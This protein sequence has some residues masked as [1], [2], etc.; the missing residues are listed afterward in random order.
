MILIYLLGC[1]NS[2]PKSEAPAKNDHPQSV[3]NGQTAGEQSSR[4][5]ASTP[6]SVE[7][8]AK[9]RALV[10][11][12][13]VLAQ[14]ADARSRSCIRPVLRGEPVPGSGSEMLFEAFFPPKDGP[15][16]SQIYEAN[17]KMLRSKSKKRRRKGE[18]KSAKQANRKGKGEANKTPKEIFI[19]DWSSFVSVCQAGIDTMRTAIQYEDNCSPLRAG[20]RSLQSLRHIT[21]LSNVIGAKIEQ[22]INVGEYRQG[23]NLMTDTL[24]A[25]QDIERGGTPFG[26]A[27]AG[28]GATIELTAP[29]KKLISVYPNTDFL[30][31]LVALQKTEISLKSFFEAE[32]LDADLTMSLPALH[33]PNWAPPG[34]WDKIDP[35]YTDEVDGIKTISMGKYTDAYTV[36]EST[37]RSYARVFEQC[38]DDNKVDD[39]YR[40]LQVLR[41]TRTPL[42]APENPAEAKLE[43]MIHVLNGIA[44]PDN[45]VYVLYASYRS[46]VLHAAQISIRW[47]LDGCPDINTFQAQN[48]SLLVDSR[49]GKNFP[50]SVDGSTLQLEPVLPL[51][52]KNREPLKWAIECNTL[53]K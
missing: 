4:E 3:N 40:G 25:L 30:A 48:L 29:L 18:K 17:N 6:Q 52:D 47:Q 22:H 23:A 31:D 12:K 27:M 20:V 35:P 16:R 21:L 9:Q 24:R 49:T 2:T 13:R 26:L 28:R 39:C 33:D 53:P 14:L 43:S 8:I 32:Q 50:A 46:F 36:L 7:E 37:T 11:E 19:P 15:C 42:R 34:G 51:L 44:G 45:S 38:S 1:L 41:E 5:S 10:I